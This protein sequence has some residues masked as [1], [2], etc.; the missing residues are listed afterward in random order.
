MNDCVNSVRPIR[1]CVKYFTKCI[2]R[3]NIC[4]HNFA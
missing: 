4:I 3:V 2:F 1:E